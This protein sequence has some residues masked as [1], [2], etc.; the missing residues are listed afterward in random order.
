[1]AGKIRGHVTIEKTGKGIK[2]QQMLAWITLLFGVGLCV[3][4]HSDQNAVGM[5]ETAANGYA[6]VAS[7]LVWMMFLRMIRW[8]CHE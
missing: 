8:W 2:F 7:A 5:T 3:V 4:G 1:M 6:T